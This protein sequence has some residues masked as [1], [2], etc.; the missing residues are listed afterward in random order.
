MTCVD[1]ASLMS[2]ASLSFVIPSFAR[3]ILT[4]ETGACPPRYRAVGGDTQSSIAI[5]FV[6]PRH[7]YASSPSGPFTCRIFGL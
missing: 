7:S 6:E 3:I 2:I 1:S 5:P 4:S